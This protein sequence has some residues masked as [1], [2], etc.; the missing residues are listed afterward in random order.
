M[1]RTELD[2]CEKCGSIWLDGP[3][4]GMLTDIMAI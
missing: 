1:G 3:K 4:L 2:Q